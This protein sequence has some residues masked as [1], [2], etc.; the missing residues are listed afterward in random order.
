MK[1]NKIL[2]YVLAFFIITG[3]ATSNYWIPKFRPFG[4]STAFT[5]ST[6]YITINKGLY[7]LDSMK[8]MKDFYVGTKG[9][10]VYLDTNREGQI[11]FTG[12]SMY[13]GNAKNKGYMYFTTNQAFVF[14][15]D[16]SGSLSDIATL[17]TNAFELTGGI[18]Q[19]IKIPTDT[20][21]DYDANDV[22]VLNRQSGRI[23]TKSLTTASGGGQDIALT[24]SLITTSSKVFTSIIYGYGTNTSF[25]NVY[26]VIT[27]SGT[28]TINIHNVSGSAFNGTIGVDF[29]IIN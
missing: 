6:N 29:F 20:V 10:K 17:D 14:M 4:T 5:D 3:F 25:A 18:T 8:V 16:I 2:F 21:S 26:H 13:L 23:L 28:T 9:G 11:Y 19:Q 27:A 1:R 12:L 22:V 15:Q 7:V 24:N